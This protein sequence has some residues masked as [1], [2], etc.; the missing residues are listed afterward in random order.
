[1]EKTI[2]T[3]QEALS[4]ELQGILFAEDKVRNEFQARFRDIRSQDVKKV[5]QAYIENA[6]NVKLMLNRVFNYLMIEPAPRK[7]EVI[8]KMIDETKYLLTH[9]TTPHLK[10]ILMIDCVKN[11]N[12]YKIAGYQT[13]YLMAVELEMDTPA[14]LIQQVLEWEL[15]TARSLS[16]LSI[17]E[18]NKIEDLTFSN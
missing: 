8:N 11:I 12:A 18:F 14:D 6:D 16:G 4:Y 15:D 1:M 5:I 10:D 7:N 9:A 3:L 13:I 2:R 17:R